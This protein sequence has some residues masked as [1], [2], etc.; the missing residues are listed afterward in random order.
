MKHP[1]KV[2][3]SACLIH[4]AKTGQPE[5]AAELLA[6]YPLSGKHALNRT[7]YIEGLILKAG[8][9]LTGAAAKFRSALADNP[10]L[11]LVRAELA[12]TLVE[13][14]QDD[15]AKHHLE[16]LAAEAPTEQDAAGIR[17]FVDKIDERRPYRINAYVALA[18][19][20]NV[21]N[22]SSHS[23][24]YS[25]LFGSNLT[26]GDDSRKVSGIGVAAG[27]NFAFSKRLGND[28]SFV[29]AGKRRSTHL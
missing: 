14:E 29:A 3:A 24:V 18:P 10:R 20:S 11:T 9:D 4:L 17:A 8:R 27:V 16:R 13:L 12:Q 15:S 1:A 26:I 23:T 2:P 25:P 5:L 7:L 21:N 19:S 22:G 28:F 6:R